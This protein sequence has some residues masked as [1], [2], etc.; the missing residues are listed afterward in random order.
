MQFNDYRNK[1]KFGLNESVENELGISSGIDELP[2]DD[3]LKNYN[4]YFKIVKR[5][6]D[7]LTPV[8]S[9]M[10]EIVSY[11][12]AQT[13]ATNEHHKKQRKDMFRKEVEKELKFMARNLPNNHP[14][15]TRIDNL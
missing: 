1:Y 4:L 9:Q 14:I 15:K 11:S 3:N 10:D 7:K 12:D 13:K 5:V 2:K 8:L 6:G